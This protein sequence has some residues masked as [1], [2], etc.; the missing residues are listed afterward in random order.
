MDRLLY[1]SYKIEESTEELIGKLNNSQNE[2]LEKQ[3][4]E[5]KA[6]NREIENQKNL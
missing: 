4:E 5:I 3:G 2:E 1:E 6:I